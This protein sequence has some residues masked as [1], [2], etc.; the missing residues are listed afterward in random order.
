MRKR[1]ARINAEVAELNAEDAENWWQDAGIEEG[2][3]ASL[4][5]TVD[6]RGRKAGH[7]VVC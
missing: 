7:L 6:G 3:F 1:K 2:S 4:R 5:M